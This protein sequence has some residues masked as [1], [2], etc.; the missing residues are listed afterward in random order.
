MTTKLILTCSLVLGLVSGC[1]ESNESKKEIK[2][3]MTY[4]EVERVRGKPW[5]ILRGANQLDLDSKEL[6]EDER[7]SAYF[8]ND[9]LSLPGAWVAR[10]VV[11]TVGNLIYVNWVYQESRLDT[12]YVFYQKYQMVLDSTPIRKYFVNDVEVTREEYGLVGDLAYYNLLGRIISKEEW[13]KRQKMG[14]G[15]VERPKKA[16]KEI[17][18]AGFKATQREMKAGVGRKYYAVQNLYCVL[19]DASS[20]R[21]V[22]SGYYPFS[23]LPVN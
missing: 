23:V 3:G 15:L 9:S 22:A 21:V 14:P 20:G 8:E 13:E 17:V 12:H 5:Q 6:G 16:R 18:K 1:R 11:K 19:F 2:V 4:D 7:K 10:E